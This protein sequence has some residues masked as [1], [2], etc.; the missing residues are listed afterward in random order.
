MFDGCFIRNENVFR[1]EKFVWFCEHRKKQSFDFSSFF[2]W[3][4][5]F[6][7]L[8]HPMFDKYFIRKVRFL[9]VLQALEVTIIWFFKFRIFKVAS[10]CLT[11]ISYKKCD[12]LWFVSIRKGKHY[13]QVFNSSITLFDKNFFWCRAN[14]IWVCKHWKKQAFDFDFGS[15]EWT[16]Y[17][18]D[19][20]ILCLITLS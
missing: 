4:E 11:E 10:Y 18:D 3:T 15:F 6:L 13:F 8:L 17:T 16:F 9:L 20:F 1:T 19:R 5:D 12:L 14:R 7:R 2:K